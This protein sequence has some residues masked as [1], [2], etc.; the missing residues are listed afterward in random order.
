[1]LNVVICVI[2]PAADHPPELH[3]HN[4]KRLIKSLQRLERFVPQQPGWNKLEIVRK[5]FVFLILKKEA[6]LNKRA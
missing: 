6:I 3:H 2:G 5:S 1:M 4:D